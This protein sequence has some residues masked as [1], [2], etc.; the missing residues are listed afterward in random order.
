MHH[1][2]LDGRPCPRTPSL[3][4]YNVLLVVSL[5]NRFDCRPVLETNCILESINFDACA[6]MK[7]LCFCLVHHGFCPTPSVPC[8]QYFLGVTRTL[9][10]FQ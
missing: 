8:H 5:K 1:P 3:S 4:I 6:A 2:P 7:A 9:N 10:G